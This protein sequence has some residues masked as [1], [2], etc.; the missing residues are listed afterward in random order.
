MGG[1]TQFQSFCVAAIFTSNPPPPS[2]HTSNERTNMSRG[3]TNDTPTHSL[4]KTFA[5]ETDDVE[6]V[7]TSMLVPFDESGSQHW[8]N[9]GLHMKAAG[10]ESLGTQLAAIV[11]AKFGTWTRR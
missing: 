8:D 10:Y 4:I 9:D 11:A 2:G 3:R 5:D 6:F 7:D 1:C